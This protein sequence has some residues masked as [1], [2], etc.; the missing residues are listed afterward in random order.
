MAKPIDRLPEDFYRAGMNAIKILVGRVRTRM[1]AEGSPVRYPI[2]WDSPKQ[3]RFVLWK[4]SKEGNLPYRRSSKYRLGWKEKS[5]P[6]GY[7]LAN[8]HPAG[9]IG[10]TPFGWQSKVTRNRWPFILKV[11]FEEL[12]KFPADFSNELRVVGKE[13]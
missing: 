9:A 2:N 6:M 8:K 13:P 10:G 1:S 5:I 7:S 12:E 11:L 3:K 4:L